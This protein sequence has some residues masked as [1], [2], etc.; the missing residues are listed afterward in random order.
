VNATIKKYVNPAKFSAVKAGDFKNKPPK[1]MP[2][3][4]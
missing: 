4:P 1:P 3:K 2:V